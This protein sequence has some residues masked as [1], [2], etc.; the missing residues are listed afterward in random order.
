MLAANAKYWGLRNIGFELMIGGRILTLSHSF[1]LKHTHTMK[2]SHTLT[3]YFPHTHACSATHSLSL[4]FPTSWIM[5]KNPVD[6]FFW[7]NL[8]KFCVRKSFFRQMW[9]LIQDG[10]PDLTFATVVVAVA[11]VAAVDVVAVVAVVAVVGFSDEAAN[12]IENFDTF[13]HS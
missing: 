8:L 11:A 10:G 7:K 13:L 9:W 2:H 6:V 12:D 4:S 5:S 1:S 3:H